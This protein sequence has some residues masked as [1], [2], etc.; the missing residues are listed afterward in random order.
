MSSIAQETE[1]IQWIRTEH[2]SNADTFAY[3][4]TQTDQEIKRYYHI[5]FKY[6]ADTSEIK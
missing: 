4:Q 5:D 6:F 3:I 1:C 2:T